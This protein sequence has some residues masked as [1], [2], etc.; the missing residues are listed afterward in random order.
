MNDVDAASH[1]PRRLSIGPLPVD[2]VT[3]E[4]A[5]HV[6]GRL[7]GSGEGGAVYTPNVDHIMLADGNAR[8]R[9]AYARCS[10]SLADGMPVLWA[11][12]LLG[13]PL[14]EKVSG[15]DFVPLLLERA[16]EQG[17]RV[18]FLG[19][20]PGVAALAREKLLERLPRLE[21]VGIDVPMIGID[22]PPDRWTPIVERIRTSNAHLVF[23][24]FG[25]PKQEIF[26]QTVRSELRPAVLLGVGASLDF[27]AGTM[28]RAPAWMSR[29][30]LEWLFRL[31]R[32]PSRLWRR[33]LIR[34]PQ[35]LM[36]VARAVR[37]RWLGP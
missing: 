27:I 4:D 21:V 31:G 25:A 22:D 15:S 23:V 18:Y 37:D 32:E 11:A 14:P 2:A 20:A 9:D 34:D 7:I 1:P 10:L 30:G 5:L 36:V 3:C 6:V 13:E 16:A 19:G 26:I 24:A 29:T 17:W 12:R 33:Y 28:P 35:F 8:M